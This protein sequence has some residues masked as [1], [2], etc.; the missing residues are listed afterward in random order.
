MNKGQGDND[1]KGATH[2]KPESKPSGKPEIK[3]GICGKGHFTIRCY[4]SRDR[5]K[6]TVQKSLA[7]VQ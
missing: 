6:R 5:N 2:S 7:E 1:N 3:C 4:K